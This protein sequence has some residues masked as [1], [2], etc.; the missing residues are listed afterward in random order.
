MTLFLKQFHHT[1]KTQSGIDQP[2]QP[3]CTPTTYVQRF[4][5]QPHMCKNNLAWVWLAGFFCL[6]A[7]I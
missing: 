2:S 6:F 7:F 5:L 3:P 1:P 4:N